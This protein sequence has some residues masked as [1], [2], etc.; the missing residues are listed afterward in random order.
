MSERARRLHAAAKPGV[1]HVTGGGS[2]FLSELLST[3]GA[4]RT[5]LDVRVP[6]A[7][8]AM[9]QLLGRLSDGACS[10][11]TARALAMSAYLHA[12]TLTDNAVF[13][14]GCTASL[15]TDREK[16][17]RH[18]AHLA[19]QTLTTTC[20]LSLAFSA[21]RSTEEQLLAD[22]MWTL[23][24]FLIDGTLA[25]NVQAVHADLERT[26][27]VFGHARAQRLGD[28][29]GTLLMPGAFNPPHTAH[30]RMLE[31]AEQLTGLPA[32]L[33]LSIANVDKPPLDY[34]TIEERLTG[35][36]RKTGRAV[37]L[38]RLPT[39]V[40]KATVF[41]GTTF[42]VGVDTITRI[43]EAKYYENEHT[44]DLALTFLAEQGC[45]FLVFGRLIGDRFRSLD[46]VTLPAALR[47]LCDSVR[48]STFREDISSTAIRNNTGPADADNTPS[49]TI[50]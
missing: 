12:R 35:I 10:V 9:H 34:A 28:H 4:S 41:P 24:D 25:G 7:A 26:D 1:F 44:R 31:L 23:C 18:R 38:T 14:F 50:D 33:E 11:S 45:R 42:I 6:Y 15:A 47:N 16:K 5:V 29:P 3:P 48:E 27:I 43:A 30:L 36:G 8:T 22:Q 39:F 21:D 37:W 13:G 49:H 17:G 46:D 19:L 40:D 2:L 20:T 32:A